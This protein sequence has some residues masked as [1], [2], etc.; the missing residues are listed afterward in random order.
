MLPDMS[1]QGR[2]GDFHGSHARIVL[3]GL[4]VRARIGVYPWE[5]KVRREL[6]LDLEMA[7][8]ACRAA[9]SD[10]PKD[11]A[12][13]YE[14]VA[15]CARAILEEEPCRL[16]EHAAWKVADG[17]LRAFSSIGEVVARLRKPL[18]HLGMEEASVEVKVRRGW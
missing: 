5:R 18:V 15:A 6:I 9:V 3:R 14:K 1:M 4:R 17:V 2:M 10:D 7:V 12:V 16:L 8:D 11:L 13:D